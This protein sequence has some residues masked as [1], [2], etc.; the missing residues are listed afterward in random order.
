MLRQPTIEKLHALRLTVMA[1]TWEEQERIPKVADLSFDE[2]SSVLVDAEH[3]A[4]DNRR[5]G[6]LLRDAN[7]RLREAWPCPVAC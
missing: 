2:R 7:L 6:R 1:Q 3:L 5:L 4:R